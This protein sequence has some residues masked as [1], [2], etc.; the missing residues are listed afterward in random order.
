MFTIYNELQ[1]P[2]E[3][4][5]N[6]K[7]DKMVILKKVPVKEN[8]RSI[9]IK[10]SKKLIFKTPFDLVNLNKKLLRAVN[11]KEPVVVIQSPLST[12]F[13]RADF[14]P[15]ILCTQTATEKAIGLITLDLCNKNIVGIN[16]TLCFIFENLCTMNELSLFVSINDETKPLVITLYDRVIDKIVKYIFTNDAGAIT[17]KKETMD[18]SDRKILHAKLRKLYEIP[19]F[20]PA[21]PTYTILGLPGVEAPPIIKME[22]YNYVPVSL[23]GNDFIKALNNLIINKYSAVTIYTEGMTDTQIE[24]AIEKAKQFMMLVYTMDSTGKVRRHKVQ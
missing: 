13:N 7:T 5:S 2:I 9:D 4:I 14:T 23:V 10:M 11:T 1:K 12:I 22:L 17:L 6:L 24:K 15:F 19:K 3:L 18:V 8:G 21:K 20:R 16:D